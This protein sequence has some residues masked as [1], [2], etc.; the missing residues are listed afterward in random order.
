MRF[1]SRARLHYAALFAGRRSAA[2]IEDGLAH[3]LGLRVRILEFQ[4][5]WREIEDEDQ[6][7]LG[8]SFA[9]LGSDVVVGSRVRSASDAFRVVVTANDL[10]QLESL[11]PSGDRFAI[12]VEALDAFAPDH[13]EW[14]LMIEIEE[15]HVPTAR[16]D[17]RSRLGWTSWLAPTGST[18]VRTDAHLRKNATH[19]FA[20]KRK[21]R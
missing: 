20:R 13:L 6:S 12:A 14:D 18:G 2:A 10:R 16:L 5:R 3:L 17:G 19:T 8:R 15:S 1:P 9:R 7:R 11:L 21:V 4:P